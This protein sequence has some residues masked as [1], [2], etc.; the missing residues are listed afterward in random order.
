[1]DGLFGVWLLIIGGAIYAYW[2]SRMTPY[3]I[4]E[5]RRGKREKAAVAHI[6]AQLGTCTVAERRQTLEA[7]RAAITSTWQVRL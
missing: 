5:E 3:Q 2:R 1:M 6:D 4:E 7:E